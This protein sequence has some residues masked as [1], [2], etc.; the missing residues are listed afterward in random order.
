M[1]LH[2]Y[3]SKELISDRGIPVPEGG[4]ASS[5][6][7]AGQVFSSLSANKAA[8]KAQ[9][10][11]G[12]RGKAGGIKLVDTAD[13][14]REAAEQ[15][16]GTRLTTHQTGPEGKPV[17]QVYVESGVDIEQEFYVGI[18]MN[19]EEESPELI[20]SSEGGVEIEE[21]AQSHPEKLFRETIHPSLNLNPF[22]TR[23]IAKKLSLSGD[24]AKQMGSILR[25]LSELYTDL[26]CTLVEINPLARTSSG[27]LAALDCKLNIDDRSLYLH[28]E[29][30]EQR[31]ESQEDPTELRA[32]EA[33]LSYIDL[34]GNIGCLVN[35]AGLAMATM[36]LIKLHGGEPANFLDVGGGADQEQVETAF[37]LI[38]SNE[39]VE[40]VLVNIFGGIMRCDVIAKGMLEALD[41]IGLQVPLVV[42][43]EGTAVEEGREL[44]EASD[45]D[46]ISV[47]GMDEAAKKA[48]EVVG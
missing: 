18:T 2:E 30:E 5:A 42:R 40:A 14:A 39:N 45:L 21:L 6:D 8:V 33:G 36:D 47:E 27:D 31:D 29:I 41:T 28:P 44:V 17:N 26:D 46:L 10:H 13:E 1:H 38:F 25:T 37:D 19:R 24:T 20:V 32:Q 7:Q 23:R 16:I 34:D 43:L 15:L 35:G 22:Q 12:G 48:V 4:V 9:V 11:A 3:Q